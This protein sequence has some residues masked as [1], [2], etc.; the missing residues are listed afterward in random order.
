VFEYTVLEEVQDISLTSY[1]TVTLLLYNI[2]FSILFLKKFPLYRICFSILWTI[3]LYRRRRGFNLFHAHV[4]HI[5]IGGGI[6]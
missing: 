3:E 6:I 5:R 1:V 4:L 2:T